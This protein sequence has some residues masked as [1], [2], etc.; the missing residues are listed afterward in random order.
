M[1][2]IATVKHWICNDQ[3]DNRH[4]VSA[5]VSERTLRE[6]YLLPFAAAVTK[7]HVGS[8][9]AANNRVN[10]EYNAEN[11]ALLHDLL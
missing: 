6:V 9:M 10:G 2:V 5:S 3:E 8:V 7:A 4:L 11:A 1:G